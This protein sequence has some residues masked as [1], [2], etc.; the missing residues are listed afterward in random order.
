M[1]RWS[2][3]TRLAGTLVVMVALVC[4]HAAIASD[5]GA[6]VIR[7]AAVHVGNGQTIENGMV[8]IE[9]GRIV[10]VGADLAVPE[11]AT[12]FEVDGS[13]TPGLIDANARLEPTDL[14]DMHDDESARA[15]LAALFNPLNQ[16]VGHFCDG[17]VACPLGHAHEKMEQD[18]ICPVCGG[19]A[20]HDH[21]LVSGVESRVS[22]TEASSE[23]V[24]HTY[25]IDSIN[26]RSPDFDRLVAGG[27][28]TVYA[29]P[30]TA[31]VIGPRGA[32]LRTGG[33]V[34]R[35]VERE[36]AA[37]QAAL[38]S[39]TWR[40]G[41][42]NGTPSRFNVST[43]TRRPNSRMG[44]SWVFRKAF[45]DAER[46]EEGLPIVGA[47][48][49]SESALK[50]VGQVRSG[51][52]PLRVTA[53]AQNDIEMAYR[54]ADQFDLSFTLLE[55]TEAYKCVDQIK[56]S[57]ASVVF[58]PIYISPS[59]VR[60]GSADARDSRL[61][62]IKALVDAGV[63][64]AL[65][66]GDLREEDGLARQAMYAMR[67]GLERQQALHLVTSSA[68]QLLGLADEVGTV[69]AGKRADL[70]IWSGEPFD[71]TSEPTVVMIE[72]QVVLDRRD[73]SN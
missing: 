72:G 14:V 34:S 49:A 71:A 17:S 42:G 23:I 38:S 48:S 20:T 45:H 69:E 57:G 53:R 47:D 51:E 63:P 21:G 4:A 68:A 56:E 28:T 66:A 19:A 1:R 29:S 46:L 60:A 35:R 33:P 54:M 32:V 59:G 52:V 67:T 26:L 44:L 13:V 40:F 65:S 41:G 39:D 5:D 12:V 11:G 6:M 50:V 27:V 73:E 3:A 10:A 25:V 22:M 31:A 55:A 18:D 37:V 2:E 16:P 62:T 9:D 61:S 64:T 7:A 8:I 43:R 70:V 36:V 24:P 58:G 30:D 15:P